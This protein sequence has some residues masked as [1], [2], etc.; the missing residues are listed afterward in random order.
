MLLLLRL[1]RH[2]ATLIVGAIAVIALLDPVILSSASFNRVYFGTDARCGALFCG[3]FCAFIAANGGWRT[4]RTARWAPALGAAILALVV[5]SAFALHD[6]GHRSVWNAGLIGCT[7]ACALGV[8]FVVERP[9]KLAA[10]ILS[11]DLLVDIGRRSYALYLWSYV[12]NTW[13]RDTGVFES[14]LVLIT[15]FLA[16]EISYRLVELP[17]L[18]LKHRF[19]TNGSAE[20]ASLDLSAATLARSSM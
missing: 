13:L 19:S 18:R 20:T 5:W 1:R 9:H 15:T 16:A 7:V 11:S 14:S 6:E 2:S 4:L 3:A 8:A 12:L 10:R 17:A